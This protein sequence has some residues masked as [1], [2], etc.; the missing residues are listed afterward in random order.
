MA[1]SFQGSI[2]D[3]LKVVRDTHRD[4]TDFNDAIGEDFGK[5][6]Y[7]AA[8]IILGSST[9]QNDLE[10]ATTF[11][12]LYVFEKS[13][14][15]IDWIGAIEEVERVT[16]TVLDNLENNSDSKEFKPQNIEPLVAENQGT[17]LSI[18]QVEWEVTGLQDFA[19]D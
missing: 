5:M 10:Y 14:T 7:P 11:T 18:V 3:K 8:S 16:D 19:A 6:T 4:D 2:S 15:S 1:E 17:R 13:P 9:Y 12:V